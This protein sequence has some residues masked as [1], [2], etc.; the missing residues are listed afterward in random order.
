MI[1]K[2]LAGWIATGRKQYQ[3]L[4]DPQLMR[5]V[6]HGDETAFSVLVGRHLSGLLAVARR[7]TGSHAEAEDIVQEAFSRLWV[8]APGWYHERADGRQLAQPSSWLYRVVVNLCIDRHRRHRTT[9]I[10]A[11]PDIKDDRPDAQKMLEDQALA[12][13]VQAA[14]DRL[15]ERQKMVLVLCMIDGISNSQAAAIMDISVGAVESLLVRA[16]K[17]LRIELADFSPARAKQKDVET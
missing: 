16:R 1:A 4:D 13:E 17:Q 12:K 5:Q 9:H 14:L 8:K 15:P 6:G 2:Q 3:D 7:Y 10:D 11:V